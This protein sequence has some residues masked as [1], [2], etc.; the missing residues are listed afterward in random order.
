MTVKIFITD[1]HLLVLEGLSA[2]LNS[3][4]NTE[5]VGMA[6]SGA[7][8]IDKLAE[9]E[10]DLL[11]ADYHMPN[12]NGLELLRLVKKQYPEKKVLILSMHED[13]SDIME[14][15]KNKA[16]G[17]ILKNSSKAE[18][19]LAIQNIMSGKTY[20]SSSVAQN[21]VIQMN[22]LEPET[23]SLS[24]QELK[25]AKE[26]TKGLSGPEIAEK[27]FISLNTV[28]THRRR[29]YQKMNIKSLQELVR[30]GVQKGWLD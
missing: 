6:Q 26:F 22:K 14:L 23:K 17:Y 20:F 2:I 24:T 3:F 5:L 11:I 25:I 15:M 16:D 10:V 9:L 4:E 21:I 28:N 12:M 29:I 1:D 30:I 27:Y 7:T 8:T 13:T 19:L 18:F